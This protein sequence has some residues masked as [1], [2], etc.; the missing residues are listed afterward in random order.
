[1][2]FDNYL[3]D[4]LKINEEILNSLLYKKLKDNISYLEHIIEDEFELLNSKYIFRGLILM[5]SD[6]HYT[7]MIINIKKDNF[8][9]D[10][11]K[12]YYYN[13]SLNNNE[14]INYSNWRDI[15]KSEIPILALY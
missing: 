10:K 1:M 9:L 14:L 7:A 13:D 11:G 8:L 5:P 6:D 12:S 4:N 15:L 2:N 3:K